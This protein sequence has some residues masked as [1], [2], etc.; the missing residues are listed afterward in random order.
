MRINVYYRAK[1]GA[2]YGIDDQHRDWGGFKPSP[3]FV[4]WWD[5]Y[6]PNGQHKEFFEPS[7]DPLRV[8]QRLWGD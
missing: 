7:G 2:Y 3:T 6:L 4:G 1:A 8:A 5:A